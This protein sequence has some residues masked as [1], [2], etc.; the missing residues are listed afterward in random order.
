MRRR[1]ALSLAPLAFA[2]V[3]L[4]ALGPSQ[5]TANESSSRTLLLG[6]R[7]VGRRAELAAAGRVEVFEF[8]AQR[9]GIARA[10]HLYLNP[11]SEARSVRVALYTNLRG[12]PG[13]VRDR[14]LLR[15]PSRGKW[16]RIGIHPLRLDTGTRYWVALLGIGGRIGLRAAAGRCDS[17]QSLRSNL[18]RF[19][20]Q[21]KFGRMGHTCPASIY[22]SGS[23]SVILQGGPAAGSG[24]SPGGGNPGS[25]PGTSAPPAG[26]QTSN[27][28]SAPGACGYPDPSYGNVGPSGSCSSLTPSGPITVSA[29]D[30]VI[31]DLNVVG[32]ITVTAADVT[33]ENVCVTTNGSAAL[34]SWGVM[35]E[36]QASNTV[37]ANTTV[38]GA[39]SSTGSID[40]AAINWSGS[41]ATLTDDYFYNC[42]ECVH[43]GP[44]TV[45]NSY[46][47][48][49][50]MVGT[51][52]H[53][54]DVYCDGEALSMTHDTLLN[55]EHQVAEV[56][57]DTNNGSGGACTNHVSVSNSL[58][59]GGGYLFYPCGNASSA[60]SSTMSITGNRFA[61]CTTSPIVQTYDGGYTCQGSTSV[62]IG[63]GEDSHGY[64]PYGGHYGV[65]SGIYCPPAS[66][67]TWS[68]NVWDDN[69]AAVGC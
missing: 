47:I 6:N 25:A 11:L 4:V 37:I 17:E 10:V 41:N 63:S 58:I 42:G 34:G 61:R 19:P 24:G 16:N 66:G 21:W 39:N 5:S 55:P 18:G 28:F 33:I 23:L 15:H 30:Q 9:S 43:D 56:F 64:W 48:S 31:Q 68:G 62:S 3:L 59:A 12:R 38:A 2:V 13:S 53:Y 35:V 29:P 50:G 27:C 1:W 65:A 8:R 20:A 40:S 52:D 54:E 67:Q 44:W 60:G 46:I 69:S 45:N 36:N 32:T 7:H 14:G 49:N 57:C 51:S 26:T 22:V